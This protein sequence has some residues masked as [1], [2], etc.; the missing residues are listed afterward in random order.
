MA[1]VAALMTEGHSG[2][3]SRWTKSASFSR[4]PPIGSMDAKHQHAQSAY[5]VFVLSTHSDYHYHH[6]SSLSLQETFLWSREPLKLALPM[7]PPCSSHNLFHTHTHR[8]NHSVRPKSFRAFSRSAQFH[9][10]KENKTNTAI[11]V[12]EG[13]PPLDYTRNV[14]GRNRHACSGLPEIRKT[15]G[16]W[17]GA[18]VLNGWLGVLGH[19]PGLVEVSPPTSSQVSVAR[20]QIRDVYISLYSAV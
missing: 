19:D 10:P 11:S 13:R 3:H 17:A 14:I 2:C 20:T 6:Y 8:L 18:F 7:H 9:V 15:R 4:A 16:S 12:V 1:D 5:S